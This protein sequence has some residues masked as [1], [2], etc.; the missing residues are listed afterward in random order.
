[1]K[2]GGRKKQN[3]MFTIG[4]HP[5]T[6]DLCVCVCALEVA[7]GGDDDVVIEYTI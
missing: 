3:Q 1:M 2:E 6:S 7:L 4:V 5:R